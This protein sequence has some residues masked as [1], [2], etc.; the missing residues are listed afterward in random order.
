MESTSSRGSNS[1]DD[2]GVLF[3]AVDVLWLASWM[4][5]G[6]YASDEMLPNVELMPD[7]EGEHASGF[8]AVGV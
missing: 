3:A 5:L 1:D 8:D 4:L 7:G 6:V 2:D